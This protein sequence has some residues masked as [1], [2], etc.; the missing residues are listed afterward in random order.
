MIEIFSD[1]CLFLRVFKKP[2]ETW[3]VMTEKPWQGVN[4]AL[5]VPGQA[6]QATNK[7]R[8]SNPRMRAGTGPYI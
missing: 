5:C 3:V 7:E 2:G 4:Y 8:A 6:V 1:L